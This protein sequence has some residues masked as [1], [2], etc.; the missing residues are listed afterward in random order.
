MRD[1]LRCLQKSSGNFGDATFAMSFDDAL[2]FSGASLFRFQR[3]HTYIGQLS[4]V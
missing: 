4:A 3:K 1:F 2:L